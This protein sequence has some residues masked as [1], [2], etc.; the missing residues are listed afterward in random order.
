M[1]KNAQLRP[2]AA[3]MQEHAFYVRAKG[4][5][6]LSLEL[7]GFLKLHK[8]KING[9]DH[10]QDYSWEYSLPKLK[11][12]CVCV[13]V[14][15]CSLCICVCVCVCVCVE[16]DNFWDA[17]FKLC[18][19]AYI[20]VKERER[21]RVYV[22]VWLAPWLSRMLAA[23][24]H[25][26]TLQNTVTHCNTLQ[27]TATHRKGSAMVTSVWGPRRTQ[28]A[29]PALSGVVILSLWLLPTECRPLLF[30][31]ATQRRRGRILRFP[32]WVQINKYINWQ[33]KL[34]TFSWKLSWICVHV[35]KYTHAH[36]NIYTYI[37]IDIYLCT[38][39]YT[40][41]YVCVCMYVYTFILLHLRWK[42]WRVS[43]TVSFSTV[44]LFLC[45]NHEEAPPFCKMC[46]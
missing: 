19:Y 21:M 5:V 38:Y 13:C 23:I 31:A 18:M 46:V 1:E 37:C 14:C 40:C 16:Q 22:C 41:L 10:E 20:C 29:A 43:I 12:V 11:C 7:M 39:V 8:A 4:A 34:R 32:Y 28:S 2:T 42:P 24:L 6:G 17:P 45:G 9:I 35:G 33:T 30:V 15:V 36:A 3:Q 26:N 27:H 25:C 44:C